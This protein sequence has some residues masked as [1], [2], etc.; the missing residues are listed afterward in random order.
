MDDAE[1]AVHIIVS[2]LAHRD[3]DRGDTKGGVEVSLAKAAN[4]GHDAYNDV[5]R[6]PRLDLWPWLVRLASLRALD[7]ILRLSTS[8]RSCS[9]TALAIPV[10][11]RKRKLL[12][13]F[14][15]LRHP[16][17]LTHVAT[18]EKQIFYRREPHV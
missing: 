17:R 3:C 16:Q 14:P 5:S 4:R 8:A 11:L 12:M 2:E 18:F 7:A 13:A 6:E 15:F 1:G 9:A 10:V